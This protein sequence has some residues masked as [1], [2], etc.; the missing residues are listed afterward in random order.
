MKL[1]HI[2]KTH[3]NKKFGRSKIVRAMVLSD[4][5]GHNEAF[6]KAAEEAKRLNIELI[7]ICGDITNFA[8]AKKAQS[9]LTPLTS[10][11]LPLLYVPGNC[12]LSSFF[13]E[14]IENAQ[15]LHA[16]CIKIKDYAFIGVGGAPSS[17][18]K[19][20]LE[21]P[22]KWIMNSLNKGFTKCSSEKKLIIL[23]HTPPFNT[24]ID[25]AHMNKH[26]G[27]QSIRQFV[28]EKKPLAVFCGH[29]H[30]SP[31]ID[32][33]GETVIVN[34][35]PAKKGNYALAEISDTVEVKLGTF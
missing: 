8:H 30:E 31:G 13:E 10:L 14:K 1:K 29:V 7:A 34:C 27:S 16:S 24:K 2:P 23:S 18:L 21:F 3:I 26:I 33:I 15:N 9:L 6:S 25:L 5:H 35:G 32:Q 22:E 11:N 19:T 12:D 20:P 4:F 17:H 28:E